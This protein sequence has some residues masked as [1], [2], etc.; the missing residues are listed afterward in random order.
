MSDK[1][2]VRAKYPNAEVGLNR[3]AYIDGFDHI[4]YEIVVPGPTVDGVYQG[5]VRLAVDCQTHEE[6]WAEAAKKIRN[7]SDVSYGPVW[8]SRRGDA[9]AD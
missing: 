6:A 3:Y 2:F 4:P 1:R 5:P 8:P 9:N 7:R